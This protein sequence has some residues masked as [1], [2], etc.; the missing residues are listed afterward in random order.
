MVFRRWQGHVFLVLSVI[1][2]SQTVP[3]SFAERLRGMGAE[4]VIEGADYEASM[5]AARQ[6]PSRS[7]TLLSD[8]TWPGMMAVS[9]SCGLSSLRA[10]AAMPARSRRH[11]FFFR[12][13]SAGLPPPWLCICAV[14]LVFPRIIVVEPDRA[15][16]LQAIRQG[17]LCD[18]GEGVYRWSAR[19][20]KG[21][22]DNT[23]SLSATATDFATLTDADVEAELPQMAAMGLFSPSG[24]AGLAAAMI[25]A[26]WACSASVLT[27]VCWSSR[28]KAPSRTE[29]HG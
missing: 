1:Y 18:A 13:G 19:L 2:L 5:A 14:H 7:A 27:V 26:R 11:I 4:V 9:V 8:S 29:R 12:P 25:G 3:A 24:G 21:V 23:A 15:P 6:V 20:Q 16:A 22:A 17:Q 28:Q 10:E